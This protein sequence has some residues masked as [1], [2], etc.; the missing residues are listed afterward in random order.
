MST[1]SMT[2]Y[3]AGNPEFL[4]ITTP[5]LDTLAYFVLIAVDMRTIDMRISRLKGNLDCIAHLTFL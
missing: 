1:Q 5:I 2:R 3:L 4:P